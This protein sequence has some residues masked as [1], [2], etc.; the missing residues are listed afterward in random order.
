LP[1]CALLAIWGCDA[2]TLG[3]KVVW[4]HD[5]VLDQGGPDGSFIAHES[6]AARL[7]GSLT[8]ATISKIRQRLKRLTLHE[9]LRR[10]DARN[11]GW[12]ATLP[13]VCLPRTHREGAAM[14]V[15][16]SRHLRS[17][18]AWSE[19]D[20]R[21]GA[22]TVDSRVHREQ[23]PRS[24]SAATAVGG[25][26]E[27]PFSASSSEAPLPSAVRE[28]RGSAHAPNLR[29]ELSDDIQ[30]PMNPAERAAFEVTLQKMAPKDAAR[31]RRV[32]GL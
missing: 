3:E 24:T 6:M 25:R 28:K 10:R 11:L 22:D 26:G 19:Q 4:Y 7:G 2:L 9:P 21:D 32:A 23:T 12:I 30:R 31:L 15:A 14:A 13:R 17:L 29:R 8:A 5:W 20:G 1:P 18:T 16:L 27:S